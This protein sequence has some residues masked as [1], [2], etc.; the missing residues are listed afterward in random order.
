M[1]TGALVAALREELGFERIGATPRVDVRA[2]AARRLL[3]ELQRLVEVGDGGAEIRRRLAPAHVGA[4]HQQRGALGGRW[5]S[6]EHGVDPAALSRGIAR[7]RQ[8][9]ARGV[10]RDRRCVILGELVRALP[11]RGRLGRMTGLVEQR[12]ARDGEPRRRA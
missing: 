9:G 12:R 10:A 2:F 4:R 7:A 8:H 5:A 11:I 1:C 3:G 6:G